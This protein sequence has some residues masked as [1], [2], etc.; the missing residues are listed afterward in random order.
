[1]T[2][3]REWANKEMLDDID[4]ALTPPPGWRDPST[5]LPLGFSDDEDDD[6][7]DWEAATR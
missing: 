2:M 6:W 7:A 4:G 1:M 3:L 5:G